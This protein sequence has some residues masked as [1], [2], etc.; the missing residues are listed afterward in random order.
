[1][2]FSFRKNGETETRIFDDATIV[3]INFDYFPNAIGYFVDYS[4]NAFIRGTTRLTVSVP[5]NPKFDEKIIIDKDDIL[6]KV[7]EYV[8]HTHATTIPIQTIHDYVLEVLL[9]SYEM[10][11]KKFTGDNE[12]NIRD[13]VD[14]FIDMLTVVPQIIKSGGKPRIDKSGNEV[15]KETA[16]KIRNRPPYPPKH[17]VGKRYQMIN[18]DKPVT[19]VVPEPNGTIQI[20]SGMTV[21][22][23]VVGTKSVS[24][25]YTGSNNPCGA[26]PMECTITFG[27]G[28]S[29][30]VYNTIAKC[31]SRAKSDVIDLVTLQD[32]LIVEFGK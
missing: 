30:K 28:D 19:I 32:M 11:E 13:L 7:Q 25:Y 22:G 14:T 20:L 29:H 6:K 5:Y 18:I 26:T 1:M 4:E 27:N 9:G 21:T 3:D 8:A 17:N 31:F 12:P 15:L 2:K 24:V 10:T 16:R 23:M